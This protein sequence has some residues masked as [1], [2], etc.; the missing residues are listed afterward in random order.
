MSIQTAAQPLPRQRAGALDPIFKPRSIAVVGASRTANTIGHQILAN[1]IRYGFTGAVYPVNPKADSVH[2]VKA[3]ASVAAVP[4]A[5]DLAVISVPKDLVLGIAEDCGKAGVRGLVVITAGFKEVGGDGVRLETELVRI[6]DKYGMRMI[7]PNCMGVLNTDPAFAMNA[8]FAPVMPPHGRTAFVSQ[9]GALGLSVLDYAAEYGIGI[10]QF[11]S[12][13]NKA[14][15]SG[16]DLLLQWEDDPQVRVILMYVENFGNPRRFL[17]IASRITRKKPVII[18]KSGRSAVGAHAAASH[19]GAL[20]ASDLAVDALLAQAGVL[21]AGSIEE[22]FDMAMAFG[23]NELPR[24]PRTVVLT[25][26]GGP[27]ILLADALEP[28]SLELVDLHSSTISKLQ[29]VLPPEASLRNPLDMIASAT[30]ANYRMVLETLLADPNI[31]AAVSIFVPP[32]GVQQTDVAEAIVSAARTAPHKPVIAVLMGREGLPQGR[33]ELSDA[34]VPAYVF[35]ES[36]ARG[37]YAL[38]RYR[39]WLER[40]RDRNEPLAVDTLRARS[41]VA[42]AVAEG[43]T[44]LDEMEALELLEAYGIA[45]AP[46]QLATSAAEASAIANRMGFPVALKIVSP[47]IMHKTDVGGVRVGLG[48]EA[49]VREAYTEIVQNCTRAVPDAIVSGVLVQ[50][51]IKGGPE[52]IVGVTRD[53]LFG[54]LVMFGLGGIYAE[55]L[56][57]VAFRIAPVG[58]A[59]AEDM[60]HAIRARKML[61]GMRGQPPVDVASLKNILRRVSQLAVDVPEVQ[62][63]DLNP[64]VAFN[65]TV[66]AVDARVKLG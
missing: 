23:A 21:R 9:S 35:P 28:Y 42:K 29:K 8:T 2:S 1:L 14:D 37:L 27:G 32:I 12:I 60:I 30:P 7:G 22:L 15:T 43:R 5:V 54:P 57:D 56:R 63:L 61:E 53:A 65:D 39:E 31:D 4:E 24:S 47:N 3:Y 26:S 16:N 52:L 33:A 50:R 64:L 55:A 19:T 20:A 45:A 13:G 62:E 25:N 48:H 40:E 66:I 34:G 46:A 38:N 58:N 10:S 11:A 59:E 6:V 36:A 41:I 51:M 49:D 44:R 18:L 17:E